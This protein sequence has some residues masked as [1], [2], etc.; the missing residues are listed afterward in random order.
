MRPSF[1]EEGGKEE[2]REAGRAEGREWMCGRDR[3]MET[4][5]GGGE[6]R[7]EC[8]MRRKGEKGAGRQRGKEESGE[9][10]LPVPSLQS[11]ADPFP[12]PTEAAVSPQSGRTH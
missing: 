12:L 1:Q 3:G 4:E 5:Q 7:E 9:K 8:G 2:E 10:T 6:V 11:L